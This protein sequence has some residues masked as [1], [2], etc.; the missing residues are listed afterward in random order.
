MV[1][2]DSPLKGMKILYQRCKDTLH[3][4]DFV[5][6][7]DWNY[8]GG[9]FDCVMDDKHTLFLRIPFKV[10]H[11]RLDAEDVAPD[12]WIE[13]GAP[14]VLRHL[15]QDENDESATVQ[16]AGA[17]VDQF[18]SPKNADAPIDEESVELARR[19]LKQIEKSF[20][21]F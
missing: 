6:G 14:F 5:L 4:F 15:Y 12:T 7:G 17:L 10:V 11:G 16:V 20:S 8:E 19:Q 3:Q 9:L 21:H 2:M 13:L 1:P 18:Q